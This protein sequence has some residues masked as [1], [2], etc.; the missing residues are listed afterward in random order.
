MIYL[1]LYAIMDLLFVVAFVINSL[2]M[3]RIYMWWRNFK[4]RVTTTKKYHIKYYHG[5]TWYTWKSVIYSIIDWIF[6]PMCI[7]LF[8]SVHVMFDICTCF[9]LFILCCF[10]IYYTHSLFQRHQLYITV[11]QR[12]YMLN[13]RILNLKDCPLLPVFLQTF[14]IC[15]F[16]S[17][18][19]L[20]YIQKKKS[21]KCD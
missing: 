9:Y 11:T 19:F 16:I 6:M 2:L 20:G 8:F 5:R 15:F 18:F 21:V 3:I 10:F 1:C 13:Y 14:S 17:L 7:I 4:N 12:D